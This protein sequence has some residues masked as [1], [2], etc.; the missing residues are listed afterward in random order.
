MLR[1][2]MFD[3]LNT[4]SE[5]YKIIIKDYQLT[6][7]LLLFWLSEWLLFNT[8]W[9]ISWQIVSSHIIIV[10]QLGKESDA[11]IQIQNGHH[12]NKFTS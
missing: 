7:S 8:K 12:P 2:L 10:T 6:L 11:Y 9:A 4:R 5:T 1:T 3:V